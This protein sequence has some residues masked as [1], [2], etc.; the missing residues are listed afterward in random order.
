MTVLSDR[1]TFRSFAIG[2]EGQDDRKTRGRRGAKK[3]GIRQKKGNGEEGNRKK[4]RGEKTFLFR[5][6]KADI[7]FLKWVKNFFVKFLQSV[8]L[9]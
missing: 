1:R 6:S 3:K 9:Q 7:Y 2:A 5:P 8:I 4:K